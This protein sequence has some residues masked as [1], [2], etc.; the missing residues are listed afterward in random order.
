MKKWLPVLICSLLAL[1]ACGGSSS[2]DD[3]LKHEDDDKD[4]ITNSQDNCPLIANTD[5]LDT[6]GDGIGDACE[7][8]TSKEQA[9]K[10]ISQYAKTNGT[11]TVPEIQ[12]YL[13]AG[14]EG[15]NSENLSMLNQAIL[16]L[17]ENDIDSLAEIQKVF[18]NLEIIVVDTD[19]DKDG[20]T[21]KLDNCPLNANPDQKDIDNDGL[22]DICDVSDDRDDDN[23][24]IINSIDNCPINSN[25]D[26]KD[27]DGNGIG[28]VC[29]IS[30]DIDNDGVINSLDNCPVNSNTNQSDKDKDGIGDICD[31]SDNRDQDNDSVLDVSDNC[32]SISNPNQLDT[33]K[34]GTGDVCD[35]VDN[36]D[37]DDDGINNSLDNC[38][39]VSN[40]NQSDLDKNG[41]GD[42]CDTTDLSDDDGDGVINILD[43]C[44]L[45]ANPDQ[46]DS[47]NDGKGNVCD[48]KDG[49]DS[50]NDGV[51]DNKDEF[52]NDSTRA[53]SVTSAYRLLTQATFGASESE[54]DRIVAIGTDAWI[55]EQLNLPSAYDSDSD[56]HKTHFER[57]IEIAE[58]IESGVD[59]FDEG[60]FNKRASGYVAYYQMSD[61]WE[62]SLGHSTN[63]RH[64]S[65]QLRQRV[66][67]AL[68]QILVTSGLDP[69]LKRRA[70]SISFYHDILTSNAFGNYRDLLGEVSRSATM[71]VYLSH[72]GNRKAHLDK[73]TRPDENFARELI[74]LFSIGLYELNL[75]GSANRDNNN[76]TFPD[77]GD[78]L[79][80]SYS[81]EDVEEIAK[82]MTGWDLKDNPSFGKTSTSQG[83]YSSYMVFNPEFHEDEVAEGGD[84]DVT[85]LGNTFALNS[86]ADGSGM[87]AVLDILF[88]HSNIAPFVSKRLI[89]LLVTS[90]PSSDY[91]A[92]VSSVFN[93]NGN[94]IKGDLKAVIYAVLSDVDARSVLT[95]DQPNFGKVKEPILAWTQLLR[96]FHVTTAD[97]FQSPKDEEGERTLINGV[98]AYRNPEADF[99]QAPFRSKSV[100]NFY[101]TDYVPSDTYF[102][103]NRLVAPE[104]QIQTDQLIVETNNT[105]YNFIK[106]YEKNKIT[107]Q[108]GKTIS[109]F[110]K[111][112]SIFSSHVML[113][114]FDREL[115]IFEL[116][117]DGDTNGDFINMDEVD[118]NDNIPYK[119]KAV[120]ALLT[121][122]DK[123]ML[124]NT[125]TSEYRAVLRHYLLNATGLES[126]NK[127]KEALHMV[128][129]SV[130]FIT[131]S[132]AFMI[133]K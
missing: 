130:R 8:I 101:R 1:S 61:W 52:P 5:Q 17:F 113:I 2:S 126:S 69:R 59:W 88:N 30:D 127:F 66:A 90:N 118:V 89:A 75:D 98:Y 124:G 55:T 11:S 68:S 36:R 112:K 116:A 122:L 103:S 106:N 95:L 38:P 37:D 87:D 96:T 85:V 60:I 27:K 34:D 119:N 20:I 91:I 23:D 29:D 115:E 114:D 35:T 73:G 51:S 46:V 33:D 107:I 67:Y 32:P 79:T 7:E 94:G 4:T 28:D 10:K 21:N 129:D 24:G 84:G 48:P 26:Q 78:N 121:H 74:Q 83:D 76:A 109:Q 104:T 14:L 93:N 110:S 56:T 50:D 108:D 70:E 65:D 132:S 42:A 16:A 25:G 12:D 3:K 41:I 72:Q 131:T 133:Q 31:P 39:N 77:A 80:P 47:D 43:N 102:S 53:A 13:N 92:R 58:L 62:N 9:I 54:I 82:V 19:L 64:G 6:D 44:P 57:T 81:Q 15:V 71:G 49:T 123:I 22:G 128:R 100:F 40:L 117:L 111:S 120:D 86:G 105:F 18:D 45:I 99:G 125:M 97:G 63:T